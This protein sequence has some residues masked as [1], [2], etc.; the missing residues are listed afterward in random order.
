MPKPPS[1]D[2]QTKY[3]L[4]CVVRFREE[5][6]D[7]FNSEFARKV[8]GRLGRVDGH[9]YPNSHPII[10][11]PALG[12]RT[13]FR[14][15]FTYRDLYLEVITDLAVIE[16]WKKEVAAHAAKLAAAREKK[17]ALAVKPE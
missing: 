5:H 10:N 3:P 2:L 8:K 1:S 16:A 17:R 14:V 13:E 6:L 9:T 4:E 15:A 12:R 7:N 11:F